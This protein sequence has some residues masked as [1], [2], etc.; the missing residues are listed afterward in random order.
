ML[1]YNKRIKAGEYGLQLLELNYDNR[2]N[3]KCEHCFSRTLGGDRRR[4]DIAN[5]KD[6]ADQAH[7]MGCWQWHFQGGEPLMWPELDD[8]VRAVGPERFYIFV[9]TNGWLMTEK[10]A[11]E[12][13][14]LGVDKICVSLDSMDAATHDAFRGKKGAHD[15]AVKALDAVR[16]AGMQANIN[17]TVSH[18]NAQSPDLLNIIRFAEENDYTVYFV[19]ATPSGAWFGREDILVTEEDRAYLVSLRERYPFVQRDLWPMFDFE[20]GCR[21]MNGFVYVTPQGDLLACT[22]IHIRIGNVLD[23]PLETVLKRGWRVKHF[24]DFKPLCLSGEDR[25]F[26]KKFMFRKT[27][28]DGLIDFKDA[29]DSEDLYLDT[30]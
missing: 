6:L 29:F 21:T 22:F 5:V 10:R 4:F 25:T 7:E 12:L 20:W 1:Q 11:Q 8:L 18:Q 26:I 2:C 3:F 28:A 24:R 9:T 17:I 23:E 16:S 30:F 13:A 27:G 14:E 15:H 19:I